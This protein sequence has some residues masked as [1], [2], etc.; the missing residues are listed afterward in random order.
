[1]AVCYGIVIRQWMIEFVTFY[2]FV[3]DFHLEVHMAQSRQYQDAQK[4]KK[5]IIGPKERFSTIVQLNDRGN[6]TMLLIFH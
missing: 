1:M 3:S 6:R 2:L 5:N 4:V